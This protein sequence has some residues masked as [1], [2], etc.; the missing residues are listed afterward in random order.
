[1]PT[2]KIS[3]DFIFPT[4]VDELSS[5]EADYQESDAP[6]KMSFPDGTPT[7]HPKNN[8]PIKMP[9][10][11]VYDT[12]D[13]DNAQSLSMLPNSVKGQR[14]ANALPGLREDNS[15]ESLPRSPPSRPGFRVEEMVTMDTSQRYKPQNDTKPKS[16]HPS[17]PET[18]VCPQIAT[19]S[20]P[21]RKALIILLRLHS[22][23]LQLFKTV[24]K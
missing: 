15:L 18:L 14:T 13:R 19:R 4:F 22:F 6:L 9:P 3:N 12:L 8:T 7:F 17:A 11:I 10:L 1:M 20:V 16:L 21:V 24:L 5:A 2:S 23:P